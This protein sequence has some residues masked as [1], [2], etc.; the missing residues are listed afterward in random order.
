MA[1]DTAFLLVSFGGPEGPDDVMPFLRNVTA[2]RNV[3]DDRLA[4]V[5]GHYDLFGGVS[6]INALC[7]ELLSA[8]RTDFAARGMDMPVYWGNRNWRPFL[9]DT[10]RTMADEGIGR[11]IAFATAAY[12]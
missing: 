2:G 12:S 11:V 1:T 10:M 5:A 8:I 7:R 9:A 3:P 6:P 4:K